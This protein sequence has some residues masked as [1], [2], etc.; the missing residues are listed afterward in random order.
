MCRGEKKKSIFSS[1]FEWPDHRAPLLA[2]REM[3]LWDT[4]TEANRNLFLDLS[5]LNLLFPSHYWHV[6]V[7]VNIAAERE[8]L[9]KLWEELHTVSYLLACTI[10]AD[11]NFCTLFNQ[12]GIHQIIWFCQNKGWGWLICVCNAVGR[13]SFTGITPISGIL[14]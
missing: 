10:A 13:F 6:Y 14:F 5:G 1:E 3:S 2:L 12:Y 7:Y 9:C 8:L 11:L 4:L